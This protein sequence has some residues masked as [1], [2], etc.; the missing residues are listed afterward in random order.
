MSFYTRIFSN[1]RSTPQK[2][3]QQREP[4]SAVTTSTPEYSKM[5]QF[6]QAPKSLLMSGQ[7]LARSD[8]RRMVEDYAELNNFFQNQKAE[9]TLNY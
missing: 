9:K 8:Y 1:R 2:D 5:M 4:E 3:P 7:F 6:T